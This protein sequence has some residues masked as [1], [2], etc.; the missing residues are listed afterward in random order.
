MMLFD[1]RSLIPRDD[2]GT[3]FVVEKCNQGTGI[4]NDVGFILPVGFH[5]IF[6]RRIRRWN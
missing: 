3:G 2:F 1:L 4:K 5:R 6:V